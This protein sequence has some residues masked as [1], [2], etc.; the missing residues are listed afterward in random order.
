MGDCLGL[1]AR[2]LSTILLAAQ[3]HQQHQKQKQKQKQKQQQQRQRQQA[4]IVVPPV[5][6]LRG[7]GIQG[8]LHLVTCE[9]SCPSH[10]GTVPR[11]R[12]QLRP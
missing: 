7:A 5:L 4:C 3:P 11:N 1:D 2:C 10:P 6:L 9:P 12:G 8:A